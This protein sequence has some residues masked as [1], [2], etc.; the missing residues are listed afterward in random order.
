MSQPANQAIRDIDLRQREVRQ[1]RG[2]PGLT[3]D[4]ENQQHGQNQRPARGHDPTHAFDVIAQ[5]RP[6]PNIPMMTTPQQKTRQRKEHWY[7]EIRAG[8][9]AIHYGTSIISR[10]ESDVRDDDSAAGDGAEAF[11]GGEEGLSAFHSVFFI[12]VG[13]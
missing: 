7:E 10:L 4:G 11:E 12:V 6:S 5:P 2:P 8:H 9:H 3:H 13:Q 1:D